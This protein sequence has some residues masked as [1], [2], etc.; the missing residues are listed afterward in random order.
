[1]P[2]STLYSYRLSG[3]DPDW[4]ETIS[5]Q[6]GATYTNL[7]PGNYRFQVRASSREGNGPVA[8]LDVPIIVKERF[9]EGAFF[10]GLA[11][12]VVVVLVLLVV[13]IRITY[14]ARQHS[15]LEA[16]IAQRTAELKA[17][18]QELLR[19]NE[20]L[21]DLALHDTLTG[22]LNR[23]GFFERAEMEVQRD[24]RSGRTFS[25]LLADLDNFK[26][27]NDTLGHVAG[28]ECLKGVAQVLSLNLR[29]ADVVARYG[30]EELILLLPE[31][32]DEIAM[33][34]AERLR[35]AIAEM[36]LTHDGHVM[37]VTIS[38]GVTSSRE[39]K[40]LDTLIAIVDRALYAAKHA[41]K[42][43]VRYQGADS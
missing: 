3:F 36:Q 11:V 12:V 7:P 8:L 43:C 19:A 23:R 35:Q 42:N 30:G 39:A 13:R 38:V 5:N 6:L 27:I 31:S 33:G 34:L 15:A 20:M 1:M 28:D 9:Y 2:A 17:N 22:L 16:E 41:G 18:Q 25:L 24:R 10:R 37:Q 29:P 14:M 21:A 26:N 4:S 40:D 32:N